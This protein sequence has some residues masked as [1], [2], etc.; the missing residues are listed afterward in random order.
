MTNEEKNEIQKLVYDNYKL[1]SNA[2]KNLSIIAC[3]LQKDGMILPDNIN[4]KGT[5]SADAGIKSGGFVSG[6][7]NRARYI[8]VGNTDL[9]LAVL[10]NWT[11]VELRAFDLYG[12]NIALNK[13]VNIGTLKSLT[14]Y[15]EN[16]VKRATPVYN[17]TN[18]VANTTAAGITDGKIYNANGQI[19][20]TKIVDK[21]PT[22][23]IIDNYTN[24]IHGNKGIYEVE[25]DL[26]QEYSIYQ[27]QLFNRMFKDDIDRWKELVSNRMSGTVVKLLDS[28]YNVN[29]VI[30]TGVW[31]NVFS[32][33]YTL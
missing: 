24:G 10:A 20:E 17:N 33:E 26:G 1:D 18:V 16:G 31:L 23:G 5:L 22:L 32:K 8:R 12:N 14:E 9:S 28:D 25:I 6:K 4:I 30:N 29:R 2:V 3:G 19:L 21:K 11:M 15:N 7:Q 27:I 13:K